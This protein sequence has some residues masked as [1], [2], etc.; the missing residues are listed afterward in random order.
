MWVC[1]THCIRFVALK[2]V[3]EYQCWRNPVDELI[4]LTKYWEEIIY[5][6]NAKV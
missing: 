4:L 3:P 2:D 6:K 1:G 5:H